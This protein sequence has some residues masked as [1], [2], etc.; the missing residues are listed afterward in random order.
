MD[1][2]AQR[3]KRRATQKQFFTECGSDLKLQRS[4]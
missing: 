1:N 4:C 3:W 2:L